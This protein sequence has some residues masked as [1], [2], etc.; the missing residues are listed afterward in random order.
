MTFA[1]RASGD[2]RALL[3]AVRRRV[4]QA[5]P[6]LP[7]FEARTLEEQAALSVL[8]ERQF[9]LLATGFGAAALLLACIGLY[10]VLS[11]AVNR[12]SREIGIRLALGAAPATVLRMVL[13]QAAL[14]TLAGCFAGLAGALGAARLLGDMLFG[15]EPSNPAALGIVTALLLLTALLA[16]CLPARRAA[17]TDPMQVL[18]YE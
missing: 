16:A 2:P 1:V 3:P 9:A 12:R 6:D 17:R 11:H 15:I 5:D 14:P 18:R 7:V 13:L 4:A 8:R 10:C